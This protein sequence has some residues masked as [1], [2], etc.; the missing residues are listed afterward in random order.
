MIALALAFTCVFCAVF[1]ICSA[2]RPDTVDGGDEADSDISGDGE[3]GDDTGN[4]EGSDI[5]DSTDGENDG[6]NTGDG[7]GNTDE[8]PDD[9]PKKRVAITLDDGPHA[10]LQKKFIDE[11][12]KYGGAATFFVVGNRIETNS[13]SGAGLAYAVQNGWE[14]GIHAWTHTAYFD[15]CA[16]D[17]YQNEVKLTSD[18][19]KK[20]VPGYDIKLLRPPGGQISSSRAKAS[21]YAIIR[22]DVDTLDYN[23]ASTA[24][25]V[26]AQN[27]QSIVDNAMAQVRDGSIILMHELY[28][29]SFLAYCEIL[30]QLDEQ[31][32]EFV[33]VSE[34]LGDKLEAGK[35]FNHG[36]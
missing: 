34:L 26:Q 18:M 25:S 13:G 1:S 16:E 31:G 4:G 28:Q 2:V 32:Y 6:A 10:G 3:N 20:Y 15:S 23:Y 33:T 21:P 9:T 11:M 36:R 14:I 35:V 29:N 22:W 19:I 7:N 24:E 17:V 27:V 12:A 5:S 8:K 30:R